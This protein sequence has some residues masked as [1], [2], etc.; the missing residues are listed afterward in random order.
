M[1]MNKNRNVKLMQVSSQVAERASCDGATNKQC[2]PAYRQSTKT[3][4]T[5]TY[6]SFADK[7]KPTQSQGTAVAAEE[8]GTNGT[9]NVQRRSIDSESV[10]TTVMKLPT[11]LVKIMEPTLSRV[12]PLVAKMVIELCSTSRTIRIL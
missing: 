1:D 3:T 4:A 5:E 6:A 12:P 2:Q 9:T 10:K 7:P 11:D 8:A